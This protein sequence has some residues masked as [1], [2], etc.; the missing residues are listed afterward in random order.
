MTRDELIEKMARATRKR[1]FER[2]GA[3]RAFDETCPLTDN[4]LDNASAALSAIESAGL[5][6]VPNVATDG[7]QKVGAMEHAMGFQRFTTA[8]IQA[9]AIYRVM[10]EEGMVK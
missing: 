9:A 10:I 6:I 8:E 2:N 7:M 4:E 1:Q 3:G 5:A